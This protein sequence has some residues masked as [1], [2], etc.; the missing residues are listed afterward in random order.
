MLPKRRFWK[1]E[2]KMKCGFS[3][4]FS[5]IRSPNRVLTTLKSASFEIRILSFVHPSQILRLKAK[6]SMPDDTKSVTRALNLCLPKTKILEGG[7]KD[8]IRIFEPLFKGASTRFG[9]INFEKYIENQH[10]IFCSSFQNLRLESI[11]LRKFQDP[12]KERS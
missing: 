9:R 12:L 2:Q 8:E 7:T 4:E 11:K 5:T 6:R 10:F 1:D 3:M